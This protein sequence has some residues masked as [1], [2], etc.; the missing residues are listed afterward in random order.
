[1]LAFLDKLDEK[2]IHFFLERQSPD[3]LMATFTLVGVRVEVVFFVD[4]MEF[5]Y[6]KGDEGVH[7]DE[8]LLDALIAENW[9]D[10]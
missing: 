3:A 10:D 6:F 1:M 9:S 4:H 7:S 8:K 5:S 2:G